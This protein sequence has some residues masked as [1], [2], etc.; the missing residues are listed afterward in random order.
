MSQPKF[1]IL[2]LP[3]SLHHCYLIAKIPK[4]NIIFVLTGLF[5]FQFW[6]PQLFLSFNFA[7]S[8][9]C[10][11]L[12]SHSSVSINPLLFPGLPHVLLS[13]N[14]LPFLYS[15][16]CFPTYYIGAEKLFFT[17]L[18]AQQPSE[19]QAHSVQLRSIIVWPGYSLPFHSERSQGGT[20]QPTEPII[21]CMFPVFAEKKLR[22]LNRQ[23][24]LALWGQKVEWDLCVPIITTETTLKPRIKILLF[25]CPDI[26]GHSK[27]AT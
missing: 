10:C 27:T 9:L 25:Q 3:S 14:H 15:F 22:N 6:K 8:H 5:V 1:L 23:F 7:C 26:L 4:R 19:S 2:S 21:C 12:S 13:L 16:S 18:Q 17:P 20:P 24:Q 11:A